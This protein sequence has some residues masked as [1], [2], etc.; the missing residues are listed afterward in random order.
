MASE[1]SIAAHHYN[2][3]SGLYDTQE[4]HIFKGVQAN[5]GCTRNELEVITGLRISSVTGRANE[6]VTNGKLFEGDTREC[7]ESGVVNKTL[8]TIKGKVNNIPKDPLYGWLRLDKYGKI[9]D[10]GDRI[11]SPCGQYQI[12]KDR[13]KYNLY[14]FHPTAQAHC[15]FIKGFNSAKEAIH[16]V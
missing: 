10:R 6:M 7:R 1:T 14:K 16:S 13:E 3:V 4:D 2:Q 9:N 11:Q 5:E 15:S 8:Y 12:H